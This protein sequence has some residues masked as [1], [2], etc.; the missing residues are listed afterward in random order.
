MSRVLLLVYPNM[1]RLATNGATIYFSEWRGGDYVARQLSALGGESGPIVIPPQLPQLIVGTSPDR[2]ALL[3]GS[4]ADAPWWLWG[5]EGG[6]PRRLGGLTGHDLTWSADGTR[7]VNLVGN[8]IVV[9]HADGSDPKV[10]YTARAPDWAE[11]SPDAEHI[12]FTNGGGDE[13]WEIGTDG[14]NPH[15]LLPAEAGFERSC[16][17]TWSRN[18]RHFVF[19]GNAQQ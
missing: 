4:S 15:P 16:C 13:I 19:E 7:L 1:Q 12:R 2:S 5:L 14:R 11:V 9:A 6:S 8:D 18:G 3:I 17:G 10:I